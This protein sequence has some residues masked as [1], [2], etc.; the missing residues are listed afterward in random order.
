LNS[1]KGGA[2]NHPPVIANQ[3][4]QVA[5]NSGNG[6]LVGTILAV[7][8]DNGQMLAYSILSGNIG[9]TFSLA[10]STGQITVANNTLLDFETNPVFTLSVQVADNGIPVMTDQA[11]ITINLMDVNEAPVISDQVFSVEHLSPN[12]TSVGTMAATDPDNGQTLTFS[13]VSGNTGGTFA[14]DPSSGLITIADNTLLDFTTNPEFVMSVQAQDNGTP[15]LSDQAT[16]TIELFVT[17]H[18]PLMDDQT[19]QIMEKSPMGTVV[20]TIDAIDPDNSQT[21]RY[22][23]LSVNMDQDPGTGNSGQTDDQKITSTI[24]ARILDNLFA[25]DT[26]SGLITIASNFLLDLST[27]PLFVLTVQVEDDGSPV[28]TAIADITIELLAVDPNDGETPT[29]TVLSGH[30]HLEKTVSLETMEPATEFSIS[31]YP[32]PATDYLNIELFNPITSESPLEITILSA[33]GELIDYQFYN[34]IMDRYSKI[35]DVSTLNKGLYMVIVQHGKVSK[36]GKF[37]KY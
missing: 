15:V 10:A 11:F 35:I 25:L 12:G 6:T 27:L 36:H 28:M 32:N 29:S 37:L 20:G 16:I 34:T 2:I 33:S 14:V 4:L 24:L 5:E 18:T 31:I 3:T 23:I 8:P 19:F 1:H 17:N 13:I 21:L 7:D 9:G 26:S 22:T 30:T